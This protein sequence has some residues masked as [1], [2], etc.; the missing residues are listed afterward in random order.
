MESITSG[1]Q[2]GSI[3]GPLLFSLFVNDIDLHFEKANVIIYADDA[4]LST[5]N[6]TNK[7]IAEGLNDDLEGLGSFFVENNLV[8]NLKKSKTDLSSLEAIRK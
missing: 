3:L 4:V 5:S 6:K 1:A 8:V 2:Q 7:E